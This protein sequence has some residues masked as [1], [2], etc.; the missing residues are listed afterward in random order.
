MAAT[1]KRTGKLVQTG[2]HERSHPNARFAAELV[3]SGRIGALQEVLV[4]LPADQG[5]HKE[6]RAFQGIPA[7]EPVPEGFDYD[8]WLGHTP[9]AP[10]HPRRCHFWWR[11]I[12]A[13]GGGEMTDRGAHVIDLAQLGMGTDDTGPVHIEATGVRTAGS[14]YDAF[15]DYGFVNTYA[16]GLKMT[17]VSKGPRGV[18]FVGED[19]WIF[20][21]VHGCKLEA[22]D[23]AILKTDPAGLSVQLGR[24]PQGDA[25]GHHRNFLDCVMS[26]KPT[27]ATAE[28]G[29]RTATIC[30]L[31]NIAMQ[32]GTSFQ[33]DPVK[34]RTDSEQAN[35]LLTP[36]MRAPWKL[37][38]A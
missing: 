21:H 12:L 1:A 33:W 14:L 30:H 18:K 13:Y 5:H 7:A 24:S 10:Y 23:P 16:N 37:P 29:H 26:R 31:N 6:A 15:W 32:T 19:G 17:G 22:S 9:M 38:E 36:K 8:L 2:S 20:V 3:R 34:E 25:N 4:Q 35:V 28:I 11:F 27:M